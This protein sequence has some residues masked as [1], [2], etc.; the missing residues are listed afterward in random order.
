M[1]EIAARRLEGNR[2]L[3]TGAASGIGA[4][5]VRRL[6]LEGAAVLACDLRGDAVKEMAQ[7][8]IRD[9]YQVIA[10][11]CDITQ[12]DDVAAACDLAEAEF[13]G[14]DVLVANAG[15]ALPGRTHETPLEHWKAVV[16]VNLTGTFLTLKHGI[17]QLLASGGGAI[18]TIG[19][20]SSVVVASGT[21]GA[22][23]KASK[24]GVL[25]LTRAVAD[26]YAHDNI[27]ANCI[28]PGGVD[29]D[30]GQNNR[31]FEEK[32]GL[33]PGTLVERGQTPLGR[34]AAPEEIAS[35]VAFLAS[36]DASFVTGAAIMVDGGYTAL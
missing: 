15:R 26:E 17:R 31:E 11:G 9:G 3:V 13:G 33:S 18:V 21:S 23:Y 4:A 28:C 7:S 24:G 25:Q 10:T 12:E 35:V 6:A 1:P 16:D 34:R 2:A 5:T 20:V 32:F 14:L 27:R 22:S 30:L 19:S 29:T 8:L 36:D